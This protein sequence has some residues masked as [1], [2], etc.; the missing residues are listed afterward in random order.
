MKKII[1][2]VS[3]QATFNNRMQ[4]MQLTSENV[5]Q[6]HDM[7]FISI[8]GTEECLKYYLDEADTVH[9]FN[10]AENVCNLEFDDI[11]HDIIY[12]G[13]Q[14]YAMSEAQAEKTFNFI[15]KIINNDVQTIT[16]HIHCRAG[17]SRSRAVAEFIFRY[18]LDNDIDVEYAERDEFFTQLNHDVLQKLQHAY[19]KHHNMYGF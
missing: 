12:H 6:R 1:I 15:D 3:S 8:I 19:W 7:A 5:E 11:T 4:F 16:F 9:Y 10:D 17:Y 14:F 18:C 13:H 2:L